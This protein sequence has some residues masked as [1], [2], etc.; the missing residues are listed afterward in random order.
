MINENIFCFWNVVFGTFHFE[1]CGGAAWNDRFNWMCSWMGSFQAYRLQVI[2]RLSHDLTGYMCVWCSWKLCTQ[3]LSIKSCLVHVFVME[4]CEI[5]GCEGM[6]EWL[7]I[8]F[9]HLFSFRNVELRNDNDFVE[10]RSGCEWWVEFLLR[11]HH[12]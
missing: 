12:N 11:N 6:M 1:M 8:L 3:V 9:I 5:V 4:R 2:Y 7:K 10:C